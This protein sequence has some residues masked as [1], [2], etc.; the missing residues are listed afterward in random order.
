ML[1]GSDRD[2]F[3]ALRELRDLVAERRKPLVIW[4][5]AGVSM[6]C[7]FPSW[8]ETAS[9]VL[10][11][12]RRLEPSFD[13]ASGQRLL[14]EERLPE[15][16]EFL[17]SVNLQR[18]NREL[19]GLFTSRTPTPVYARFLNTIKALAPL[20]VITTNVEE[21][22]ERNLPD[23]ETVQTADIERCLDLFS[24]ERP[25][26]AKLHGSVSSIES[27][28]F[29]ASDYQQLMA[30]GTCLATLQVLF[31]QAAIVFVGYSLRDKYVLDLLLASSSARPLF[32]DGPHFLVQAGQGPALPPSVRAIR[33]IPEPHGDHRSAVTV[34]DIIRVTK[35]VGAE[36]FAPEN[37]EGAGG[38]FSSAYFLTDVTPPGTWTS[39]Q[40]LVLGGSGPWMAPNAIVG[41]GFDDSELP[42]R[43]SPAMHDL[44]VGLVSFDRVYVPLSYAGQLHNLLGFTTFWE[45]VRAGVF[46][47]IYFEQQ[48]VAMFRSVEAVDA[49][50]IGTLRLNAANGG[51]LTIQEEIE[52]Q[53]Q[54]T[55]R[56][57]SE[58]SQLLG[59]LAGN[60]SAF[61][62]ARFN[63]PSLT[64]GAL[65]HPSVRRLLGI[66]DAVLPNSFPRWSTLPVIRLAHTIM[67]G[68]ACENFSLAATKIGFGSE[69]LIGA[70]FAVSAAR[71]WADSVASY[72]VT[73]RFNSDLGAYLE[74]TPSVWAATLAFRDTQAGV[75]LRREILQEV[76]TNAGAEFMASVNGG[77]R[78]IVPSAVM[79][80]AR[81]QL[82]ELMFRRSVESRVVPV[83]WTNVRNSDAI[84]RLWRA[85][86]RRELE[87]YCRKM[88]IR[89]NDLCP[90]ASGEKLRDCCAQ[91]LA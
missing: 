15:L 23:A 30:R 65:L 82:S 21:T 47:F 40:S 72:V 17:R 73:G 20:H 22:L 85:R 87:A 90:C 8:M 16:F 56:R 67:A 83:V 31:A 25:F 68:C 54:P 10:A 12:F 7:G 18:Y 74:A 58:A 52:R 42:Q 27:V 32:G 29:A 4:V 70:A 62:H 33:Y 80:N 63:I 28:V 49:G 71:D 81:D 6:W 66:S 79:D 2:T 91:A 45:F 84:A 19:V 9:S 1:N 14:Q 11:S 5:G 76:A 69:I 13:R 64:R 89:P 75:N 41:Q 51:P 78:H 35:D 48:P 36:W 37:Q 77:L 59:V 46:H 43:V 53:S 57:E 61:D 60:T 88:G 86:S 3:H 34:L 55:P 39:G 50:D 44:M 26:V 24:G 38:A